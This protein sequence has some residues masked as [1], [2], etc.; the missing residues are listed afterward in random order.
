MPI[1]LLLPEN[2]PDWIVHLLARLK[3]SNLYFRSF[4]PIEQVMLPIIT[5]IQ[6]VASSVGV[7]V[8]FLSKDISD[9]R[10]HNLR[11]SFIAGLAHGMGKVTL[12]IQKLDYTIPLDYRDEVKMFRQQRTINDY[13]YHFVSQVANKLHSPS[14]VGEAGHEFLANLDLGQ[15]TAE[16]EES[17]LHCYFLKTDEFRRTLRGE[18][19]IIVGRKGT[20]KTAIFNQMNR[21]LSSDASAIVIDLKPEEFQLLK[22]KELVID[23]LES[24]TKEHTVIAFWEYV[25]LLET[26]FRI[27]EIDRE[28]H[29]RDPRLYEQYVELHSTYYH[30]G[31]F[32]ESDLYERMTH[33][34]DTIGAYYRRNHGI[35]KNVRLSTSQITE[36]LYD[37]DINALRSN[38]EKYL[39]TKSSYYILVDNLDKGWPAHGISKE[40]V[41]LI[42]CLLE[43][44]RKIERA[45]QRQRI[46]CHSVVFIRNDIYEL[47]LE[48]TPDRGKE[49]KISLDWQSKKMLCEILRKR[50]VYN[51]LPDETPF[52]DVWSRI[53]CP[54]YQGD[55]SFQ[56]LVERSLMRPRFL[57]YIITYCKSYAINMGH[58]RI[59]PEDIEQGLKTY[60][61]EI[62]QQ[63]NFEIS[64]ALPEAT[65]ILYI[66]LEAPYR[67][68]HSELMNLLLLEGYDTIISERIVEIFLWYGVLGLVRSEDTATYIYDLHYDVRKMQILVRNMGKE[69]VLY[70]INPAF[71][72]GLQIEAR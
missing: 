19:R 9:S 32:Q 2:R 65:G 35:S 29:S 59:E 17:S 3:K 60:S 63:I 69:K 16:N 23:Y 7:V 13:V 39:R 24:G 27:L 55:D 4:D 10:I 20:G 61:G 5:A 47:L 40:D 41:L 22:F 72:P 58:E 12:L 44:T 14:A 50:L 57:L 1:Y 46:D 68:P 18:G 51:D 62:V 31:T 8:P 48:S 67:I 26:C 66:L 28:R 15:Y 25:I 33:L 34:V 42:R 21:Q 64:S 70:E 53:A 37:H 11:A 30:K 56:Y 6:N 38:V 49:S 52:N 71:W 43:A 36:F 54:F 45:M